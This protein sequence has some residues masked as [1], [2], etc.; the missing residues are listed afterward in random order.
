MTVKRR[1][2]RIGGRPTRVF[3]KTMN[4]PIKVSSIGFF[5]VSKLMEKHK[6]E[7]R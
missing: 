1:K 4:P 6:G 7:L 5:M 2:T 3:G